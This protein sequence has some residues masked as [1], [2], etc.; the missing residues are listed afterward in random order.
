MALG[1]R[2]TSFVRSALHSPQVRRSVRDLGRAGVRALQE[3]R[4]GRRAEA[5]PA[6]PDWATPD[7]GPTREGSDAQRESS[8][9][10]DRDPRTP[11]EITYAPRQDNDPDPGEVVWAWVPFEEDM[12]RGKD[13]P[14][15]VLAQEDASRGGTDGRGEVLVALMLTSRDRAGSGA[16]M[17]DEHGAT[18]VDVGS[19]AWDAKG[20]P[21]EVRVDRLLRLAPAAVRR[22]GARLDEARFAQVAQ[23]VRTVH[24]WSDDVPAPSG[25][26]A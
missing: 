8:A 17:T 11:V 16:V 19:G 20:R 3:Q 22:E 26:T 6:D 14:V 10:A 4:G 13:R 1:S 15:L 25:D 18:W 9:L 2:L 21:S 23:A 5:R 12:T 7:D 24:G